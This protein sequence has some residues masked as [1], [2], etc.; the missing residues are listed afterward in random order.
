[1]PDEGTRKV[2][3]V[4]THAPCVR[5]RPF[6]YDLPCRFSCFNSR[7]LREGATSRFISCVFRWIVSTHAPCVRARRAVAYRYIAHA[8]VSTHAPCVRARHPL[9]ARISNQYQRFNSRALREGA[10]IRAGMASGEGI[11]STHA[12]CVRARLYRPRSLGNRYCFNSRALR[13]GAT[14]LKS[15]G[16]CG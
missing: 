1:V 15:N 6:A 13:E 8:H 16:R 5:A 10:T 4:S 12:P 9:R 14:S 11:V 3:S 7:A 2:L